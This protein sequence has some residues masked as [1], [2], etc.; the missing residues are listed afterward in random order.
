[1][2]AYCLFYQNDGYQTALIEQAFCAPI[3]NPDTNVPIP[4]NDSIETYSGI[5]DC[6]VRRKGQLFVCDHKSVSKLSDDYWH[7][8]K[9]NPQLTHYMLGLRHIGL[10]VDG[11]LWDVILKPTISPKDLSKKAIVEIESDGTYCGQP[12][13]EPYNGEERETPSLF[14]LRLLVEYTERPEKYFIRRTYTRD[15]SQL[16]EYATELAADVI[17]IRTIE[18][19]KQLCRRNLTGCKAFNSLCTFHQIC[20]GSTDE[21]T[22]IDKP[23]RP[24]DHPH[25]RSGSFS[26]S[27]LAVMKLCKRKFHY[28]YYQKIAK[29]VREYNDA[30]E[31]GSLLHAGLEIYLRGKMCPSDEQVDLRAL[32]ERVLNEFS[33]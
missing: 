32:S 2:T 26:P 20:S 10:P 4:R 15:D 31:F 3:I 28:E 27:R 6:M 11:F 14:G 22:Y 18:S 25:V 29:P 19:D 13:R 7:E 30:L 33:G 1:M 23:E 17:E 5:I 12:L 16:Y 8:L 9:T 21:S 24:N